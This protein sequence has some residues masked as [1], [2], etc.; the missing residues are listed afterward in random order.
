MSDVPPT[1]DVLLQ[2]TPHP[3]WIIV[4][5][6]PSGTTEQLIGLFTAASFAQ[7]WITYRSQI[8]IAQEQSKLE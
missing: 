8:W 1:F 6:W 7:D 2:E 4:A 3:G 5:H